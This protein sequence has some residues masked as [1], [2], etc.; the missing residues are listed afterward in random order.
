MR[1]YVLCYRFS[2]QQRL[3]PFDLFFIDLIIYLSQN[4]KLEQASQEVRFGTQLI[5]TMK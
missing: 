5:N 2:M 3:L 1:I 4:F